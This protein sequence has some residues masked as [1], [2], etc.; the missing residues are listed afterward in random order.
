MSSTGIELGSTSTRPSRGAR[1][2]EAARVTP[3]NAPESPSAPA[4]PTPAAAP[5]PVVSALEAKKEPAKVSL[6]TR[7]LANTDTRLA[8][9]V[10]KYDFKLTDVVDVALQELMSRYNVPEVNPVNGKVDTE[11]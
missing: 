3:E 5:V 1:R 4:A 9:F 6:S 11:Q 2:E 8:W 7:I 10:K